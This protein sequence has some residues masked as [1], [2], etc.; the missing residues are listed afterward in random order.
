M[1]RRLLPV[2]SL[3]LLAPLVAEYLLGS[4]PMSL[5]TILPLTRRKV[6]HKPGLRRVEF[7]RTFWG[8]RLQGTRKGYPY[9][10]CR[11]DTKRIQTYIVGAPLAGA[12]ITPSPFHRRDAG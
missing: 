1:L 8:A 2:F 6:L 3:W 4:L 10:T 12:L 7:S 9:S 5:I 11:A